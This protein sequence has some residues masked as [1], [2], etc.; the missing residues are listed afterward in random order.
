MTSIDK[1]QIQKVTVSDEDGKSVEAYVIPV[2]IPLE[3]VAAHL[4][5][6]DSESGSH[7]LSAQAK[8]IARAVLDALKAA[9]EG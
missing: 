1:S 3:D 6:Y 7:P 2:I 9:M 4:A 5:E 8:P